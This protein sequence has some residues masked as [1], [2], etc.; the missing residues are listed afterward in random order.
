MEA[1][2]ERLTG[3]RK[4]GATG[5]TIKMD[6]TKGTGGYRRRRKSGEKRGVREEG[7]VSGT[8]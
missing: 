2:N 8:S 3:S 6:R 7:E 1:F 4:P 5:R